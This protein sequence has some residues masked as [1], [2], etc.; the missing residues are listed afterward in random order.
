M[1]TPNVRLEHAEV[2]KATMYLASRMAEFANGRYKFMKLRK[3]VSTAIGKKVSPLALTKILDTMGIKALK[4]RDGAA[5]FPN[6]GAAKAHKYGERMAILTD[7][8]VEMKAMMKDMKAKMSILFEENNVL[9]KKVSHLV[10]INELLLERAGG[11][12]P[13]DRSGVV[14][15][16]NKPAE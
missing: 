6:G 12:S 15:T 16:P 14:I 10:T 5:P 8:V 1:G 3:E 9:M 11:G 7:S 2:T 13:G 4:L